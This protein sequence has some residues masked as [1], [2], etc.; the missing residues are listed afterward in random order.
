LLEILE[1]FSGQTPLVAPHFEI[2]HL[3]LSDTQF[4]ARV[5]GSL[6]GPVYVSGRLGRKGD[7]NKGKAKVDF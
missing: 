7:G 3:L 1:P 6:P 2:G 4:L 5:F